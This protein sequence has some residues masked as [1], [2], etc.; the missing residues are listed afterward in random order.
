MQ[1]GLPFDGEQAAAL[2][3]NGAL[4]RAAGTSGRWSLYYLNVYNAA[5]GGQAGGFAGVGNG[6]SVGI[7]HH[8]LGHALA[9]R[10]FGSWSAIR[11]SRC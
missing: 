7:L 11:R 8:E 4:K 10:A 6:T 2:D 1:T 3:W 9:F 5:A